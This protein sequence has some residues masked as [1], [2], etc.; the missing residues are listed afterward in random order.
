M[1]LEKYLTLTKTNIILAIA[2]AL[3]AIVLLVF[4]IMRK[5]RSFDYKLKAGD[6]ELTIQSL[7]IVYAAV[8]FLAITS[9]VHILYASNIY[10]FYSKGV[11][12]MKQSVRWIEYAITA[13]IMAVIIALISGVKT[14]NTLIGLG[15]LIALV[16]GTG[17]WFEYMYTDDWNWSIFAP[18][19]VGFGLL[20]VYI[21]IVMKSFFDAKK[22]YEEKEKAKGSDK[23]LPSWIT[24]SVI[25]TLGFFSIF[26]VVPLLKLIFKISNMWYEY[27]YLFLSLTAKLYLGFF[28]GWGLLQ[29]TE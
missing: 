21:F 23:T 14:I 7:W 17:A 26:G 28:L 6:K 11:S 1:F 10:E 3:A 24:W 22:E 20:A 9:L 15:A 4:A 5:D 18:L 8:A 2:H 29:R 19:I 13:T 16:M 27:I 12:E 25:G